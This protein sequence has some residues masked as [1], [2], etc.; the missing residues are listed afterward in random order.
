MR[1]GDKGRRSAPDW[2]VEGGRERLQV[3]SKT[4]SVS[5]AFGTQKISDEDVLNC[6]QQTE[7]KIQSRNARKQLKF[8]LLNCSTVKVRLNC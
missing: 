4:R 1:L 6:F 5:Q 2:S 3:S 8:Q 7:E